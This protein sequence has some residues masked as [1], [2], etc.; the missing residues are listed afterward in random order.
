VTSRDRV[1]RTEAVVLR[2]LDLGEAD[3]LLTLLTP[4]FGKLRV[5]AKGVR[6]PRSRKA[7]HLE[8]FSR[9]ELLLARGRDLDIITQAE[10]IQGSA[11][12]QSDL[13]RLAHAAYV[14]ELL[15][16][17]AVAEEENRPLYRL[18]VDTL[19]RLEQGH[20]PGLVV[21]FFEV[22][23]LDLTGF[24]P[25][26]FRC[27]VC[28]SETR[29]EDQYF[30]TTDGG[31]LC[32]TCGPVHRAARPL[33][34]GAL[35]VLRHFQRSGFPAVCDLRMS[36]GVQREL[37]DHMERYLTYVLERRLHTPDFLHRVRS[38]LQADLERAAT[39][40]QVQT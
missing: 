23:V 9:V 1:Y 2:R 22:R 14:V 7:G 40:A 27:Q 12:L 38:M 18:L 25:Q 6:K 33:S 34:L 37:E 35:K 32:P 26:L 10:A 36:A 31:V 3:R 24:Q 30:S 20:D 5:V 21:R 17:F 4:G 15:D 16:A 29:P 8:L 28:G 19:D 13:V 39:S 11:A